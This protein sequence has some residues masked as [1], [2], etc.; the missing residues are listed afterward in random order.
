MTASR[1][2]SAELPPGLVPGTDPLELFPALPAAGQ[3]LFQAFRFTLRDIALEIGDE[4]PPQE[5]ASIG[6]SQRDSSNGISRAPS[7]ANARFSLEATVPGGQ[8]RIRLISP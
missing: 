5:K 4:F 7:S 8:P 1:P 6:A 3:V 2:E